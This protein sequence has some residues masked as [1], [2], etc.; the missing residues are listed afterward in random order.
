M[1]DEHAMSDER[2]VSS[3]VVVGVDPDTA[4]RVFTEEM[5]LWWVRGPINFFDAGRVVEMRCEPGVGGRIGEVLDHRVTG[6]FKARAEITLWEPGA[7]IGWSSLIDDVQTDVR[8]E[9]TPVGTRVRVEH[10]IPVG[11][12]DQ[13][14]TSWSRVV[15][16]WLK[17]WCTKRNTVPHE[18]IDIARLAVALYYARPSAA[19]HWLADVFQL[20]PVSTLPAEPDP[21]PKGEHG[22]PWIEFRVGNGSVMVFE[23]DA[24]SSGGPTHETWVYVD[25]VA[26]HLAHAQAGGARVVRTMEWGWL[27]SYVALDLEGNR[28]TF[29]QA[30]P[31]QR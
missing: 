2:I 13:G 6:E 25:D 7:R 19:A 28:W 27:P 16:T 22:A 30:R 31:T 20:E 21:L 23:L 9:E 5:D 12:Q 29:A 17:A 24:V 10:R 18:Q 15:P 8:F 11:G 26:A 1:S 4:F 3:E 14:G